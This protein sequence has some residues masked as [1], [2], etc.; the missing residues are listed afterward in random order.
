MNKSTTQRTPPASEVQAGLFHRWRIKPTQIA[1]A[2][3]AAVAFAATMTGLI[4]GLWPALKP[5]GAPTIKG[6]TLNKV[7]IER[8]NF[9]QYL[10]RIPLSRSGYRQAR[11][12]RNGVRVSFNLDIKGYRTKHLPLQW[13]LIDARTGDR[14]AHSRDLFLTPEATEDQGAWRIW[15]SVPRGHER[16]FF[17][18]VE[19]LVDRQ[20]APL[21]QVRTRRF[22]GT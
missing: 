18:E 14:V 19:L 9:G 4:F 12:H 11:L 22:A 6:A 20:V 8:M 17:V 15:L 1:K 2:V 7:K 13:Q 10:D 3:S 16:R 21:D 5:A